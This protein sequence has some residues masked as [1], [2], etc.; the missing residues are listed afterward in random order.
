MRT[1][2]TWPVAAGSLVLGFAVAQATGV[3]P[4][5]GVLLALG[6]GW[7]AL[8]WREEAGTGT[9]VALVAL[10]LAGFVASHLIADAL[11][12]W[13]AVATVAAG[14]GLAAWALGDRPGATPRATMS[15]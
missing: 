7:C 10:Y 6:A 12:T 13:G 9:A 4:L 11:G 1:L 14:V 3:R 15:A 8:R 5:G 2:P